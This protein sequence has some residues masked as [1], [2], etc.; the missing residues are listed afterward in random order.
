[1]MENNSKTT[2]AD[3]DN[4]IIYTLIPIQQPTTYHKHTNKN[5]TL[6]HKNYQYHNFFT[7]HHNNYQ[8]TYIHIR[9]PN[10]PLKS[11]IH[12]HHVHERTNTN[13][14]PKIWMEK[15]DFKHL[16]YMRGSRSPIPVSHPPSLDTMHAISLVSLSK[17]AFSKCRLKNGL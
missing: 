3:V 4:T 8:Y 5:N 12:I 13:K 15:V 7:Q 11:D 1:M 10:F 9:Q 17:F 14:P 2:T 16:I 6:R